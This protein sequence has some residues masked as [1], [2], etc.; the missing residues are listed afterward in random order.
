M[1]EFLKDQ[2]RRLLLLV[3]VIAALVVLDLLFPRKP[4][5]D[6]AYDAA[7]TAAYA[8]I[9]A[10]ISESRSSWTYPDLEHFAS[11]MGFEIVSMDD[12]ELWTF[13]D[14]QAFAARCGYEIYSEN[15]S[16]YV[17][18]SSGIYHRRFDCPALPAPHTMI[19]EQDAED[20]GFSACPLCSS[21]D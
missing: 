21:A 3:G 8:D 16:V 5:S 19:P 1:L 6:A 17:H 12:A 7:Y 2:G 18:G 11:E 15:N 9:Q 4:Y 20:C 14:L 13:D 10:E